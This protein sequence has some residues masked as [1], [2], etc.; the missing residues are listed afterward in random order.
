MGR[1]VS[2]VLDALGLEWLEMTRLDEVAAQLD[3][4]AKTCFSTELPVA[5]LVSTLLSGGKR[6]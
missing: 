5:L 6:A 1:A 4:A 2:G 3:A